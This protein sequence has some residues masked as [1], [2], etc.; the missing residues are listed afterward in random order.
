MHGY[1]KCTPAQAGLSLHP[2][3]QAGLVS[4]SCL[5]LLFY[6]FLVPT[7]C[8]PTCT[9]TNVCPILAVKFLNLLVYQLENVRPGAAG[10]HSTGETL[11]TSVCILGRQVFA[12]PLLV[13]GLKNM[14]T[15]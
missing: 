13:S 14:Q 1:H 6:A 10:F 7:R 5:L 2:R 8:I 15:Q 9:Y 11:Q 3:R 4:C 12:A